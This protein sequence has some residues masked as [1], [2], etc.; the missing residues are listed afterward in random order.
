[1]RCNF[2]LHSE[3]LSC[4]SSVKLLHCMATANQQATDEPFKPYHALCSAWC[5]TPNAVQCCVSRQW[6]S[7]NNLHLSAQA[8]TNQAMTACSH[9]C[10][11]HAGQS[12]LYMCSLFSMMHMKWS[13][14]SCRCRPRDRRAIMHTCQDTNMTMLLTQLTWSH[15]SALAL[16]ASR[17]MM[18]PAMRTTTPQMARPT[19]CCIL[20]CT[21]AC[22]CHYSYNFSLTVVS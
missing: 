16:P 5:W 11:K 15:L 1:M 14:W 10:R 8:Y 6:K 19:C 9:A 7:N 4:A 22:C 17:D 13:C 2:L 3:A 12:Y 21:T 18:S 20:P